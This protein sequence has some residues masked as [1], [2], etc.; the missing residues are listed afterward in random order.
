MKILFFQNNLNLTKMKNLIFVCLSMLM[1]FSCKKSAQNTANSTNDQARVN[2][3]AAFYTGTLPCPNCDGIVTVLT[4]NA[5][6]KRSF[7]M[8]EQY[9]GNESKTVSSAGT[10]TV[11]GDVVTLTQQSGVSKYQVTG[12]GLISMNADG[13]KR[14]AA[15]ANLYLLKKVL[16]E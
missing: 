10:W 14:D 6:E 13:S 8:E 16:G 7:S 9:M 12:E 1:L 11:A 15:S 3:L 5:D 4:L 2:E